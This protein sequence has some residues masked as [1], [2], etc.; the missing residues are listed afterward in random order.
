MNP[1][2]Q[3]L[4]AGLLAAIVVGVGA[5]LLVDY[6]RKK[7]FQDQVDGKKPEKKIDPSQKIS[8]DKPEAEYPLVTAVMEGL[9]MKSGQNLFDR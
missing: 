7:D 8:Y 4:F 3:I 6:I 9:R 5:P 2:E 1:N